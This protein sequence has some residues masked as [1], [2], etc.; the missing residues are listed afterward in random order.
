ML[1]H[2]R[3]L[4]ILSCHVITFL[5]FFNIEDFLQSASPLRRVSG[6][7]NIPSKHQAAKAR[8]ATEPTSPTLATTQPNSP[9]LLNTASMYQS[10][11]GSS[12]PQPAL[13]VDT[14]AAPLNT[15]PTPTDIDT[16][17]AVSNWLAT[18]QTFEQPPTAA[19]NA[20]PTPPR[21][22]LPKEHWLGISKT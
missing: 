1:T 4:Y 9:E 6:H 2:W 5:A 17:T 13:P 20:D 12:Y 10:Q 19:S 21:K 7:R 15:T 11:K 3:L 8:E 18:S 22:R 16:Y 14:E